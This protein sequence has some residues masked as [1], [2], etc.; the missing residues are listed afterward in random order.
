VVD[1]SSLSLEELI[2]KAKTMVNKNCVSGRYKTEFVPNQVIV[3]VDQSIASTYSTEVM[4]DFKANGVSVVLRDTVNRISYPVGQTE[5]VIFTPTRIKLTEDY[6]AIVHK[7]H[8]KVGCQSISF[9][10]IDE[11]HK[12]IHAED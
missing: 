4:Q 9:E 6:D 12:L 5:L 1:L 8:V 3:A 2:A 10:K 11:L 7:D